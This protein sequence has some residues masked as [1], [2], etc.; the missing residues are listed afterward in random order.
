M[1]AASRPSVSAIMPVFNGLATID[2]AIESVV[3]Q[4]N[5][6]WELLAIDDRSSDGTYERLLE[7]GGR[8]PRVRVLHNEENLGPSAAR[9]AGLRQAKGVSVAFLDCDDRFYPDYFG[10]V[11]RLH[12]KADVLVFGYDY[13]TEGSDGPVRSWD[14]TPS[15]DQFFMRNLS[16]P[17]G[18][19]HRREL[20]E[21][22]GGFDEALWCLED[23]DYW[24]RL[25]RTG[26]EFLYLPYKSG[27]YQFRKGSRSHSPRLT[28]HQAT[29]F[30]ARSKSGDLYRDARQP[31][32]HGRPARKILFASLPP[33]LDPSS[34]S[35]TAA[36]DA[37]ELLARLGFVCQAFSGGRW[38]S[39]DGPAMDQVLRS[40]S[41]PYE[42]RRCKLGPYLADI[43]YARAGGLPVTAVRFP[44]PPA[45]ESPIL[46]FN[47]FLA[48]YEK[49]IEAFRPDV[50]ITG[51][52]DP[53]S[54]ILSVALTSIPKRWDIPV[55]QMSLNPFAHQNDR[56]LL[57]VDHYVVGSEFARRC[58]WESRRV[59]CRVLP[60]AVDW[61]RVRTE[62]RSPRF[63]TF[64]DPTPERGLHVFA[65]IVV[66]L[67]RRRPDIPV[68]V[69]D[70][71]GTPWWKHTGLD[72]AGA[73]NL[74]SVG[75]GGDP[76]HYFA[77]TK[78]LITP[79]VD[80]GAYPLA[81]VEAMINGIPVV[82][83][84][85]GAATEVVGDAG[86]ALAL[87]ERQMVQS[88]A[89]P[90]TAE[91]EP[92]IEAIIRLWDDPAAYR[93][94]S[95]GALRQAQL[96]HPDRLGPMYREFFANLACQPGPPMIPA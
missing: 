49:T 30:E 23:W 50:V 89:I 60:P 39:G 21:R 5:G 6:S 2:H 76:R 65:R 78:L 84:D 54:D 44:E 29:A 38:G 42:I 87:P 80:F 8:D 63:V 26:A 10:H 64:I 19:A 61:A 71:A 36:A 13:L 94:A 70:P 58:H 73:D 9:N 75:P 88:V 25:A 45:E 34:D 11:A 57:N 66:E 83:S 82:T 62:V 79:T 41:L 95:D 90:T 18:V 69:V 24:K 72:L 68:L 92:W 86:I 16:V 55:V 43:L 85:R 37:M 14:P 81:A 51:I 27:L 15:K 40:R 91:V 31:E 52:A 59:S 93:H 1:A 3:H 17:L 20:W 12:D 96:W 4:T 53:H 32:A 67:G 74:Q 33:Y 56:F 48:F 47:T 28:T 22:A 77:V 35:A 7:W 46:W